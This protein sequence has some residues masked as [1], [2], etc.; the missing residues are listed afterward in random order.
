MSAKPLLLIKR[1][2]GA[3]ILRRTLLCGL[4]ALSITGT[5]IGADT[6]SVSESGQNPY[7]AIDGGQSVPAEK[8]A[9][10]PNGSFSHR[11]GGGCPCSDCEK[12]WQLTLEPYVWAPSLEGTFA[13]KGVSAAVDASLSDL[14]DG[15]EWG[16]MGR[17]ELRNGRFLL[18]TDSILMKEAV[19]S[20][21]SKSSKILFGN[22]E[23]ALNLEASLEMKFW[24]Q[25]LLAGYRLCENRLECIDSNGRERRLALDLLFGL[26][27]YQLNA[28]LT[29]NA[30]FAVAGS[31]GG[32]S[33]RSPKRRSL[34]RGQLD[35]AGRRGAAEL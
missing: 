14:L 16:V 11:E 9:Y 29:A 6:L 19:G 18:L 15:L 3:F 26:R 35:R 7:A 24:F 31:G 4:T 2:L 20:D 13:V 17:T 30:E 5:L 21:V 34:R 28:D 32:G 22:A 33:T 1:V 27:H 12:P 8:P 25:E 23:T 10:Q